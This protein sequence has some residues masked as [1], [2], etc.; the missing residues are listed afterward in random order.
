MAYNI[1]PLSFGELLD[2][3]FQVYKD[4]FLLFFTMAAVVFIPYQIAIALC[5]RIWATL[6][7]IPLLALLTVGPV[8]HGAMTLAVADVYLD[9]PTTAIDSYRGIRAILRP[10]LWTYLVLV[11]I[12]GGVGTVAGI[13]LFFRPIG[14]YLA[15]LVGAVLFYFLISWT[16]TFQI[17]VVEHLFGMKA[18]NRSYNLVRGSWWRTLGIAVVTSLITGIPTG[19]L[20]FIWMHIPIL[21]VILQGATASVAAPYT[22]IA[23]MLYYFDRRCR[24]E[25]FDLLRLADQIRVDAAA[26]TAGVVAGQTSVG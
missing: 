5:V 17:V 3:A 19:A 25:N 10:Y 4:Q 7:I 9:K 22:S 15:L 13:A 8:M 23:L 6:A 11:L 12:G 1:R 24:L 14:I 26:A 16:L 2:R 21:G 20:S 18:I